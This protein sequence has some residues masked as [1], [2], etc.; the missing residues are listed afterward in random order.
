M[1]TRRVRGLEENHLPTSRACIQGARAWAREHLRGIVRA[2]QEWECLENLAPFS[3]AVTNLVAFEVGRRPMLKTLRAVWSRRMQKLY[4]FLLS[5]VGLRWFGPESRRSCL[6]GVVLWGAEHIVHHCPC[7]ARAS[8]LDVFVARN[9][10]KLET[11]FS[12]L[13][14]WT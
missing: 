8:A 14:R 6:C 2:A 9:E 1:C 5:D 11:L 3:Y 12:H 4:L 10:D 13:G 7:F